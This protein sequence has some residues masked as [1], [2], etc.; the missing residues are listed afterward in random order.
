[1]AESM[2]QLKTSMK[3]A[4]HDS[5]KTIADLMTDG[6]DMGI[7]SLSKYLNQYAAADE[8]SKGMAKK[9]IEIE[10]DL[11]KQLRDFL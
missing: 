7:K 10:E 9:L 6:C 4:M 11:R 2:S 3:M 5:D 8:Q 1:M